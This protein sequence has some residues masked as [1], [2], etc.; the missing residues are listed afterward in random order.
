MRKNANSVN[1]YH[2]VSNLT[3]EQHDGQFA[4]DGTSK[5]ADIKKSMYQAGGGVELSER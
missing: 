2:I 4:Y 1:D 3:N 5:E